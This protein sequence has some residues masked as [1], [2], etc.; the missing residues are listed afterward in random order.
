[1]VGDDD[2]YGYCSLNFPFCQKAWCLDDEKKRE[3]EK[4]IEDLVKREKIKK[5]HQKRRVLQ[6]R[7]ARQLAIWVLTSLADLPKEAVCH[8]M[9]NRVTWQT[10]SVGLTGCLG[11]LW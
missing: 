7:D 10:C 9:S 2:T 3:R 1:M 4:E 6:G 8:V 11:L 5:S